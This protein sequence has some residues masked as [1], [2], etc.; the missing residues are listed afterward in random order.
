MITFQQACSNIVESE[1]QLM[2]DLHTLIQVC[3]CTCMHV[4]VHVYTFY[5]RA[6]INY[7]SLPSFSLPLPPPLSLVCFSLYHSLCISLSL[8]V[9][10]CVCVQ[11]D[12]QLLEEQEAVL[13]AVNAVDHDIDEFVQTME[14]IYHQKLD[15]LTKFGGYIHYTNRCIH[16][17]MLDVWLVVHVH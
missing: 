11:E 5:C 16:V 15:R 10:V 9:C 2:E 14:N 12:R 1:E 6:E 13:T 3:T 7:P 8:S 4:H 17:Y